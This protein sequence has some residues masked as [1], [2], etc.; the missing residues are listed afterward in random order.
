MHDHKKTDGKSPGGT[1]LVPGIAPRRST[2]IHV[3]SPGIKP[4]ETLIKGIKQAPA[5]L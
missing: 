1:R 2:A 5:C 4:A 3:T